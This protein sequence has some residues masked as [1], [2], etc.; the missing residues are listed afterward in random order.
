MK[1][2]VIR[3]IAEKNMLR[4]IITNVAKN[5]KDED[6]KDLEQDLYLE[7]M[8]KDDELID[9]LY[10]NDQLNYYMTRMVMNNINSKTSRFYYIYKKNKNISTQIEDAP[11]KGER[12]DY[13]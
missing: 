12:A 10:N 9:F 7:L 8:E 3:M 11:D 6:L 13:D 2:D 5:N 1:Q 4:D